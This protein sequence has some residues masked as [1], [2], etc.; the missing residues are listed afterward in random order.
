[1]QN[2]SVLSGNLSFLNLGDLLQMLGAN[3][4]TGVLR[5]TNRYAEDP[6][7]IYLKK[8]NPIN[9]QFGSLTGIDAAYSLFGCI[10]GEFEFTPKQIKKEK[11]IKM[12]RMNLILDGLSMLDEGRIK[13]IGP[14]SLKKTYSGS[15]NKYDTIPLVKGPF[16]DYVYIV[17]EERFANNEMI[18]EEG[19]HGNW[20]WIILE[21]VVDIVKKTDEGE[22][23]ILKLGAGTFIGS[24][25]SLSVRGS[26]RDITAIASGSVVLGV[27]D[28]QRLSNEYTCMSDR[29][30]SFIV[31]LDN[32]LKRISNRAKEIYLKKDGSKNFTKNKKLIIKEGEI[33]KTSAYMI[34]QGKAFVARKINDDY[35][36]LLTLYKGDFIGNMPFIDMGLEPYFAS[37]FGSDNIILSEIDLVELQQEYYQL[38]HTSKNIIENSA[39]C[40]SAMAMQALEFY[41]KGKMP[42]LHTGQ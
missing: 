6:G 37:V 26:S 4:T 9:A 19:N 21:G 18:V 29:F 32:R 22:L 23:V 36:N 15:V 42:I 27:L 40:I 25:S 35:F 13:K 11:V 20:I 24:F 41:N 14:V 8:G 3:R 31:C 28:K 33:Q 38:S 39:N 34:T 1:M 30:R 10:D 7:L 16:I 12:S 5:I 2:R 17:D